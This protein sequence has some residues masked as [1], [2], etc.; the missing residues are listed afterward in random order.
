MKSLFDNDIYLEDKSK[1]K[2]SHLKKEVVPLDRLK[3]L[4][5]KITGAV[6]KVKALKEDKITLEKKIKDLE[7]LLNEKNLEVEALK[8]EKV[9]IKDQV[10]ELLS[11][12][13]TL[14]L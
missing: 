9:S 6:E 1:E 3:N 2:S 11:E 10:E 12:L 14:E 5:E 4:E 7:D 8:K 13:E